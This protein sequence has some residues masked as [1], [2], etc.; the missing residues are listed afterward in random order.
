MDLAA[1]A[2]DELARRRAR[3]S[4]A[5]RRNPAEREAA[6]RH[7]RLWAGIAA[8]FGA[9]LPEDLRPYEGWQL[10][11]DHAPREASAAQWRTLL[12][13]ELRGAAQ[14]ATRRAEREPS[15][16]ALTRARHLLALDHPLSLAAGLGPMRWDQEE[17]IAA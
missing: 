3:C 2:A 12:A 5:V 15:A 1:I 10:W 14:A 16:E 13:A 6:E 11:T 17:S 9:L 7:V 4:A 8:W